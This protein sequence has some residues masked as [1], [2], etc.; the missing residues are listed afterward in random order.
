METPK[1]ESREET[2][3]DSLVGELSKLPSVGKKS[4]Q[5]LAYFLLQ[6][7]TENVQKLAQ[8]ILVARE[9]VHPCSLCGNYT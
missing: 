6:Q 9:Q 2:L 5:R 7:K 1:L 4:A 3:I 8:T